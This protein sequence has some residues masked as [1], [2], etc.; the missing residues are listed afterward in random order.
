MHELKEEIRKIYEQADNWL[1][2]LLQLGVWLAS[3]KI[4]N[5]LYVATTC[6]TENQ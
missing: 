1:T 5:V 4:G 6:S 2:G 3:A